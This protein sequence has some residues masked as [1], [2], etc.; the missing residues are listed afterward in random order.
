MI[1]QESAFDIVLGLED[2]TAEGLAPTKRPV[3][4]AIPTAYEYEDGVMV[5]T[6]PLQDTDTPDAANEN[7]P[8]ARDRK[9]GPGF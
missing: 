1:P 6:Y 3:P 7:M 4:N 5:S 9:S 2:V 8:R